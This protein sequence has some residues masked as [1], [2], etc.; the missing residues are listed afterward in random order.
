MNL[1]VIMENVFTMA[2]IVMGTISAMTKVMKVTVLAIPL[3]S[4]YYIDDHVILA[5]LVKVTN[6]I[7]VG[8]IHY[9]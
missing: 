2:L 7:N 9:K 1:S 4:L 6:T 8:I 5:L 3:V